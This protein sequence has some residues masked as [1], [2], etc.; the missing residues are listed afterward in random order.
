MIDC[1]A[2][3]KARYTYIGHPIYRL[4]VKGRLFDDSI[5]GRITKAVERMEESVVS[6]ESTR[7]A[8]DNRLGIV[9]LEGQA[10]GIIIDGRGLIVTN[11]HVIDDATRVQVTLR[12]GRTFVG[13]VIGTDKPTDLAL[14]R[15][16]SDHLTAARL[17]DSD[18]LKAGQMVLAIGNALGLPGDPTVSMGVISALGRPLPGTDFV[19]EGLIQT[20]AS[21]NPGNSGGPLAD[22]EANVIGM[23]TAMMPFAQGVGFAI[24]V[25]TIKQVVEQILN[26][27]RVIRPWLGISGVGLNPAIARRFNL[28][29]ETGV[30]LVGI[31]PYSPAYEAGLKEGDI[32]IQVGELRVKDM[33]GLIQALS[34]LQI[35]QALRIMALRVGR[36]YETSV[37]IME[38]PAQ[39]A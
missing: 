14:V 13:E 9:P 25:N 26:N 29:T 22:L 21:I 36:P 7:L 3:K 16:D 30:F 37:R 4:P 19:L 34:R 23:N 28:P 17:G 24:P 20:D 11:N 6:I 1:E 2:P 27:G 12:D 32:I 8:R 10:S 39:G 35:G 15:V 33:K 38:A 31:A 18:A 5:Q